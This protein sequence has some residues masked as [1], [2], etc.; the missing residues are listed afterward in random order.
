MARGQILLAMQANLLA[1]FAFGTTII[2]GM[3][4]LYGVISGKNWRPQWLAQPQF[5]K[6]LLLCLFLFWGANLI[7]QWSRGHA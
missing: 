4:A 1:P 3:F 5:L 6:W 2:A 7:C